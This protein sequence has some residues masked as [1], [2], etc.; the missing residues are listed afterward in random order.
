MSDIA[1]HNA[2]IRHIAW[3]AHALKRRTQCPLCNTALTAYN[4]HMHHVIALSNL[5][6]EGKATYPHTLVCFLCESC[7][8]HS[9]RGTVDSP[10]VRTSLLK[11][12][13]EIWGIQ[14]VRNGVAYLK[15]Y[16]VTDIGGIEI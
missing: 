1:R 6:E 12:L 9:A 13:A 16:L 4:A 10:A 5:V 7:H 14:A 15:N 11:R 8:L 2:Y 3:S